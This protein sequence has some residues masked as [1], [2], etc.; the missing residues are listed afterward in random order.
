MLT[1]IKIEKSLAVFAS[2]FIWLIFFFRVSTNKFPNYTYNTHVNILQNEIFFL[3]EIILRSPIYLFEFFWFLQTQNPFLYH[4]FCCCSLKPT[5]YIEFYD[6]Q[7]SN[8]N[9]TNVYT[10]RTFFV[11][12]QFIGPFLLSGHG[13][14]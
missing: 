13:W 11:V 4:S 14:I 5:N 10:P 12:K 7:F 1:Q 2:S 8:N 6:Q 9:L 3:L